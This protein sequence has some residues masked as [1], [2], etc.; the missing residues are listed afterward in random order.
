MDLLEYF[1]ENKPNNGIFYPRKLSLPI[2]GSFQLIGARG[3]GK[4]TLLV[5]Y[6]RSQEEKKW[7]YIDCQDPV[8]ALEDID[9]ILLEQFVKEE[10]ISIVALDHYFE[11]FLES[12]PDTVDII[13]SSR[14]KM[15]S[16]DL[17]VYELF[18]L[19][20]EEF[21]S[22]ERHPSPS[23]S[24]N[25]FLRAGTLPLS[26]HKDSSELQKAFRQFFYASFDENESRLMLILAKL[27]GRRLTTHQIYTYAREYFRISKDWT[28]HTIKRFVDEK[29]I[30]LI[31]DISQKGASKMVLY[32]YALSKYLIKDQPFGVTFD[33]MIA[34]ALIKHGF[35]I[36]SYGSRGY[37]AGDEMIIPS[38]FESQEQAWKKS[39]NELSKYRKLGIKHIWLITVSEHYSYKLGEITFEGIP[40]YEWSVV[41]G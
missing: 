28:Y 23:H 18:G 30:Y 39:Y 17:P 3:V 7:L 11:G 36:D 9:S 29:L 4:S 34:L 8:F 35:D 1:M 24:F 25:R 10:K 26:S 19:D 12:L 40:F 21:L 15:P 20:Y 38:P 5:E 33:A 27:Q 16:I 31:P 22:F 2:K 32:D 6:L 37:L 14:R 13:I 41:S